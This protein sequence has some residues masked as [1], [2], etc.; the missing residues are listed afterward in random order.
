MVVAT[1]CHMFC[2]LTQLPRVW[3]RFLSTVVYRLALPYL[4]SFLTFFLLPAT[5]FTRLLAAAMFRHVL[6][7]NTNAAL[8][9]LAGHCSA[10]AGALPLKPRGTRLF[11]RLTCVLLLLSASLDPAR[12]R[13]SA[14]GVR[15]GVFVRAC[16]VAPLEGYS[17]LGG[18]IVVATGAILRAPP[19]LFRL[20]CLRTCLSRTF[21]SFYSVSLLCRANSFSASRRAALREGLRPWGRTKKEA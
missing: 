8:R 17:L 16:S 9:P 7:E 18:D 15:A 10:Y 5:A 12:L 19:V 11:L 3:R 21:L 4:F 14:S 6:Y 13:C 2:C 1:S 20:T